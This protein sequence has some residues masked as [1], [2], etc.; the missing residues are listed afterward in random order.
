MAGRDVRCPFA[1]EMVYAIK[2]RQYFDQIEKAYSYASKLVLNLLMDEQQL[3]ARL[4]FAFKATCYSKQLRHR[5]IVTL[6]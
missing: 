6:V 3:L 1:E 5:F 2:E 4:R